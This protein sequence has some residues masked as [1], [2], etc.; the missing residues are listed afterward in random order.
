MS[1]YAHKY[2]V[3][4]V[5]FSHDSRFILSG[6]DDNLV[7]IWNLEGC[8]IKCFEGHSDWV[9]AVC[10]SFNGESVVSASNDRVLKVWDVESMNERVSLNGFDEIANTVSFSKCGK[11]IVV[12]SIYRVLA[13]FK[14]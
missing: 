6:A 3:R 14:F 12:E 5:T 9:L 13:V 1:F 11:Y 8:E 10:F 7:K 4:S 2:W